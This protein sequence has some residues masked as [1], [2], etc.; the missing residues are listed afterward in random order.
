MRYGTVMGFPVV[1]HPTWLIVFALLIVSLVSSISIPDVERLPGAESL[2]VGALVV[3]LFI[4]SMVA[5]ELAHATVARRRGVAD[6][7]VRLLTPGGAESDTRIEPAR[8]EFAIAIAG[9]VVSLLIGIVCVALALAI[10]ADAEGTL[11]LVYWTLLWVGLANLVLAAF[12]LIPAVPLDGGRIVRAMALSRSGDRSSATRVAAVIGRAF[13]YGLVGGGLVLV[14][15]SP[16]IFVGIW[17][18]LLGWFTG[19]LARG[20]VERQR[21]GELTA[22]LTVSDLIDPDVPSVPAAVTLDTLLSQDERDVRSGGVYTVVDGEDVLGVIETR[23]LRRTLWGRQGEQRVGDI[24][25][26]LS[27]VSGLT[28]TTAL[29]NAVDRFETEGKDVL[30]VIDSAGEASLAGVLRRAT[31]LERLRARQAVPVPGLDR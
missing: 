13:G 4:G 19:R 29:V 6:P 22:G 18:I 27:E 21:V 12:H 7:R 28:P 23:P 26:P 10:P 30:V 1:V 11:A 17:L 14:A 8:S 5:H 16:Q 20:S 9:P 3:V 31:V 15:V 25:T 2:A 24:A